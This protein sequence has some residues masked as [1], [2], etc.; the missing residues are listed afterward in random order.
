MLRGLLEIERIWS[1]SMKRLVRLGNVYV[2]WS[3]PVFLF[4]VCFLVHFI[5]V[6][7]ARGLVP[8]EDGTL[9]C[10]RM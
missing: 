2:R 7:M 8:L 1:C 4:P 10:R 6:V 9:S 5:R 3:G